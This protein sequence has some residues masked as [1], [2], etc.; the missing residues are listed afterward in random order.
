M[1]KSHK[2]LCF[3]NKL[4]MLATVALNINIYNDL[5]NRQK[6]NGKNIINW[7]NKWFN[8]DKKNR[9]NSYK[10]QR[11]N[12]IQNNNYNYINKF[13]LSCLTTA[14]F[15]IFYSINK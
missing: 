3:D 7:R 11:Q 8:I 14:C 6:N 2:L 9:L 10:K 5:I 15:L 12:N 13:R 1:I 4:D